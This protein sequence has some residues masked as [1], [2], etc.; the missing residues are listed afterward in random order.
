MGNLSRLQRAKAEKGRTLKTDSERISQKHEDAN[1]SAENIAVNA[2]R[3]KLTLADSKYS[4]NTMINNS[5]SERIHIPRTVEK[6]NTSVPKTPSPSTEREPENI[7]N[8]AD[9]SLAMVLDTLERHYPDI[10]AGMISDIRAAS[11]AD[12]KSSEGE[13]GTASMAARSKPIDYNKFVAL[14]NK[15]PP[16][17]NPNYDPRELSEPGNSSLHFLSVWTNMMDASVIASLAEARREEDRNVAASSITSTA[18]ASPPMITGTPKSNAKSPNEIVER[19]ASDFSN[20][21]RANE[22]SATEADAETLATKVREIVTL[23][24]DREHA[25]FFS[26]WGDR[27]ERPGHKPARIRT[28]ILNGLPRDT[29]F[30]LVQS[31]VFG[32]ALEL[33]HLIPE[34]SAAYVTYIDPEKC[35]KFYNTHA[36]GIT[37]ASTDGRKTFCEVN[38]LKTVEPISGVLNAQLECGATRAI[39]AT[40]VDEEWRLRA[41]QKIGEVNGGTLVAVNET[42]KDTGA[43]VVT[44]C[45]AK[46]GEATRF[47]YYLLN[48]DDFELCKVDFAADPCATEAPTMKTVHMDCKGRCHF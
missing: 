46:V 47:R 24:E 21:S 1:L 19:R 45:F 4:P 33:I 8:S 11:L 16:I 7:G 36:N 10:H 9:Q 37:F 26:S 15:G 31:L 40:G 23:Q 14:R 48:N 29:T 6:E 44:W 42:I 38:R 17:L 39:V 30:A 28:I 3:P 18:A 34:K 20:A 12:R 25:K 22:G 13:T 2:R 27:V 35:D 43:R 5:R 41:L 32:G